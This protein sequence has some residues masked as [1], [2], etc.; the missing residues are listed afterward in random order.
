MRTDSSRWCFA[1]SLCVFFI[2]PVSFAKGTKEIIVSRHHEHTHI[3]GI[4]YTVSLKG[5]LPANLQ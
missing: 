3:E 5:D 1:F 4:A 2:A